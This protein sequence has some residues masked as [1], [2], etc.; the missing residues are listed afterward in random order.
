MDASYSSDDT[1]TNGGDNKDMKKSAESERDP[2][3][4]L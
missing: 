4:P 3:L 1:I 2:Y